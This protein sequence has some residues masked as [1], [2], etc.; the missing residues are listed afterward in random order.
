MTATTNR[1]GIALP[2][3]IFIITL[4]TIML[5]AAFARVGAER[6]VAVGASEAISALTVAQSG[7][8]RYLGMKTVRPPDG[9]SVRFNVTGGYTDVVARIV[10]SDSL[11]DQK[12]MYIVRSTGYVIVPAQGATAQGKRTVAQ[13]AQW[14]VGAIRRIAAYVAANGI[15]VQNP[16]ARVFVSGR[17][18]CATASTLLSA[19]VA[20]GS[21][22]LNRGT[23]EP[24]PPRAVAGGSGNFVADTTGVD[25]NSIVNGG[26]VP[27]Y[28]YINTADLDYKSH[29]VQ[30]NAPL[31]NTIGRGLLIVTGDL[32][33]SGSSAG[34][35]GIVLVGGRIIFS[36]GTNSR[37]EGLVFSGLNE[38]LGGAPPANT[39]LGG[40]GG[41]TRYHLYYCSPYVD[42]TLAALTGFA[43]I[44]NAWVDNWASY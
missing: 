36:N 17:D 43:P 15:D 5:A 41:G 26:F 14:Q 1:R 23:F 34:W 27:D 2:V 28:R 16:A 33:T 4:M 29:M 21:K 40:S 10:E 32:T 42:A 3:T 30:G 25:W 7:L 35:Q 11:D 39:V 8:Q 31:S 24:D 6:E 18:S 20:S 37:F 22:N 9:D 12:T 44:R 13:F 38:L 19:R